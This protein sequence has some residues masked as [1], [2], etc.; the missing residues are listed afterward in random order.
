LDA[1]NASAK[2]NVNLIVDHQ[3]VGRLHGRMLSKLKRVKRGTKS[4]N[5]HMG[6]G[7]K[8]IQIPH[9]SLRDTLD[10]GLNLLGKF[11]RRGKKVFCTTV[12][13]G[14]NLLLNG[15][16][17]LMHKNPPFFKLPEPFVH[18]L[19]S[20]NETGQKIRPQIK[21]PVQAASYFLARLS[22]DRTSTGFLIFQKP[23]AQLDRI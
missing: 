5:D 20:G 16:S 23:F 9:S 11:F 21:N 18:G 15:P 22:D 10:F 1:R 14:R 6:P 3:I 4:L 17:G 19:P 8:H 2:P 12:W 7:E 13:I